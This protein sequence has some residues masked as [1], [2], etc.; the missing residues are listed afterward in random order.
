[1]HLWNMIPELQGSF[2]FAG[3]KIASS[4]TD[5]P[6]TRFLTLLALSPCPRIS[7]PPPLNP[8][9]YNLHYNNLDYIALM[10]DADGAIDAKVI[11]VFP[12][13]TSH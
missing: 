2:G 13:A 5:S 10:M 1:M 6:R 4:L 8:E 12:D 3:R 9:D 11:A 7:D